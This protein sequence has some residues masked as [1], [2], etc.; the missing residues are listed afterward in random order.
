MKKVSHQ[1]LEFE[2]AIADSFSEEEFTTIESPLPRRVFRLT[3]VAEVLIPET[4]G[5]LKIAFVS[6]HHHEL[7]KKLRRL[8]KRVKLI[9]L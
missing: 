8:G 3:V 5:K 1:N 4:A 7:F 2:E 6:R 9:R